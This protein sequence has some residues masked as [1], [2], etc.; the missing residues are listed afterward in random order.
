M[1]IFQKLLLLFVLTG[2]ASCSDDF[3]N[4]EN[5]GALAAFAIPSVGGGS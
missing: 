1:K 2:M 3:V 4:V 5:P